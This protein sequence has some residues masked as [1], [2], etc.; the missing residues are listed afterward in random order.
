MILKYVRKYSEARKTIQKGNANRRN[1]IPIRDGPRKLRPLAH[2]ISQHSY[3][4]CTVFLRE[5]RVWSRRGCHQVQVLSQEADDYDF[6]VLELTSAASRP[7][8]RTDPHPRRPKSAADRRGGSLEGGG[9][10]PRRPPTAL[11]SGRMCA[12]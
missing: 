11:R 2:D 6:E 12:R 8:T 5:T 4:A 3:F 9:P 10:P 7:S 1:D